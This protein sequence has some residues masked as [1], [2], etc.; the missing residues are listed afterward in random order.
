MLQGLAAL[1]SPPIQGLSAP[2][3][4]LCLPHRGQR[5]PC[6]PSIETTQAEDM[7]TL[8]P[9]PPALLHPGSSTRLEPPQPRCPRHLGRGCVAGRDSNFWKG[10]FR[11]GGQAQCPPNHSIPTCSR[12]PRPTRDTGVLRDGHV[13]KF[14]P[15][16]GSL[17]DDRPRGVLPHLE[18]VPVDLISLTTG[19][20]CLRAEPPWGRQGKAHSCSDTWIQLCLNPFP[21][22]T[23]CAPI[24]FLFCNWNVLANPQRKLCADNLLP[25]STGSQVGTGHVCH[26][27][28]ESSP[29]ALHS[30]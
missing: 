13:T 29:E 16:R 25:G 12:G 7:G 3:A 5:A 28:P 10:G 4:A 22:Q 17:L 30:P 20:G 24:H 27:H 6:Q 11:E 1:Q 9:P 18:L 19:G 14:R 23:D 26:L 21:P 15:M 2:T 8:L